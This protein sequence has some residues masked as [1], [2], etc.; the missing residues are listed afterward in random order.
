MYFRTLLYSVEFRCIIK[1]HRLGN[2]SSQYND[3]HVEDMWSFYVQFESTIDATHLSRTFHG[4]FQLLYL[5]KY[6]L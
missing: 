2:A 5:A 6:I 3:A 1:V 4:R